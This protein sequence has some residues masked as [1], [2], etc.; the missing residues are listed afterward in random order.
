MRIIFNTHKMQT[1]KTKKFYN[2]NLIA[3]LFLLKLAFLLSASEARLRNL[4]IFSS[5]IHLTINRKGQQKFLSDSYVGAQPDEVIVNEIK[6]NYTGNKCY[7]DKNKNNVTLIF[8]E[9]ILS[10]DNMF[11]NLANIIEI[12]LTNLNTSEVTNMTNMFSRCSSLQKINFGNI[13]TSSV[14]YMKNMFSNC[15]SLISIDIS[16]LD[17]SQVEDISYIFSGCLYLVAINLENINTSSVQ[18]MKGLFKHCE[19][20]KSIDLSNFDTSKVIDMTEMFSLKRTFYFLKKNNDFYGF[21]KEI[22]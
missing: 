16:N 21:L 22:I 12:D 10:C 4:I 13:D 8:N 6:V 7:M 19:K 9:T 20:L 1:I 3:F 17:T 2:I 18:N 15:I 11:Y 5:E 14:K